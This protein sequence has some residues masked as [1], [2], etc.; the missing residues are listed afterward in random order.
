[1][2]QVRAS[3]A[4]GPLKDTHEEDGE[5]A[6][7]GGDGEEEREGLEVKSLDSFSA[8][9]PSSSVFSDQIDLLRCL[10]ESVVTDKQ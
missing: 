8:K 10:A 4:T 9:I 1:M 5:D 7:G 3:C 6:G 2:T